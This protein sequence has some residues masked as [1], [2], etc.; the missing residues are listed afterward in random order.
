[1]LRSQFH[2]RLQNAVNLSV[3]GALGEQEQCWREEADAD[4]HREEANSEH[5]KVR[6][7]TYSKRAIVRERTGYG[8][9]NTRTILCSMLKYWV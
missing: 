2:V 3:R 9:E 5:Q 7:E 1:M 8:L 6:L 4:E